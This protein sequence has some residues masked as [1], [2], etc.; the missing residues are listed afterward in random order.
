MGKIKDSIV[1]IT[2]DVAEVV[3]DSVTDEGLLSELPVVGWV[4]KAARSSNTISDKI[5]LKKLEAFLNNFHGMT[6]AEKQK[7]RSRLEN[8]EERE[9]IGQQLVFVLE[10]ADELAK[11]ELLAK[12]FRVYLEEKL[13]REDLMRFWHAIDRSFLNDLELLSCYQSESTEQQA[14]GTGLLATGLV[15]QAGIDGGRIGEEGSGGIVFIL[16]PLGKIFFE[17]IING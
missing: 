11:A 2:S 12:C 5:F 15:R 17:K 8:D 9:R 6:E 3:L 10:R 14:A 7:M 1:E 4:V 16:T 13:A